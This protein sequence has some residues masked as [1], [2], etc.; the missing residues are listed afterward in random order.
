M[1]NSRENEV[2]HQQRRS[3]WCRVRGRQEEYWWWW[4]SAE[5][6]WGVQTQ[7]KERWWG[8]RS[9]YAADQPIQG[10]PRQKVTEVKSIEWNWDAPTPE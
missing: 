3:A 10:E 9:A 7:A 2:C 1:M 6:N 5:W 8:L 4:R